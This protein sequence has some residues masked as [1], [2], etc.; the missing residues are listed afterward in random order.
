MAL[1][2]HKSKRR[3][4]GGRRKPKRKKRKYE[5]GS[6]TMP[7]QV[8]DKKTKKIRT[9]GGDNK[10]RALK[11][12]KA[13]ITDPETG[14]TKPAKINEVTENKANPHYVRRDIITKGAIIDTEEGKARVT[15]RPGQEGAVN[16]TLIK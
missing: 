1:Y 9:M 10:T 12:N 8:G 3:Q 4:S 7:T 6:E 11:I 14:E 16:A 15:N 5:L 2:H 13:N